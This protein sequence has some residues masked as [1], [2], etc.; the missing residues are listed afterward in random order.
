L[1]ARQ[2]V[3]SWGRWWQ[4]KQGRQGKTCTFTSPTPHTTPLLTTAFQTELDRG[5]CMLRGKHCRQGNRC[6][7]TPPTPKTCTCTPPKPHTTP[8]LTTA[9]QTEQSLTEARACKETREAA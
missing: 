2:Q 9:F 1:Q 4:G 6:T 3:T 8:L 7:F 5:A